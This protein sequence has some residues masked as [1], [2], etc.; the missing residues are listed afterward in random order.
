MTMDDTSANYRQFFEAQNRRIDTL[1]GRRIIVLAAVAIILFGLVVALKSPWYVWMWTTVVYGVF[2]YG[3]SLLRRALKVTRAAVKDLAKVSA[4]LGEPRRRDELTEFLKNAVAPDDSNVP[5]S[6]AALCTGQA[7]GHA[8]RSAANASFAQPTSQLFVAQ[9]V[10]TSLVLAG[11]FGTVLFFA[12]ELGNEELLTGDLATLL[13]GIRGALASTLAGILG[14]VSLG[15]LASSIDQVIEESIWETESLLNGPFLQALSE[16]PVRTDVESEHQ[17]WRALI[18]EV[19]GLRRETGAVVSQLGTDVAAHTTA[20]AAL[21]QRLAGMPALQVPEELTRLNDV[22]GDFRRGMELLETSVTSIVSTAATLNVAVPA[23]TTDRLGEIAGTLE[24]LSET[25]ARSAAAAVAAAENAERRVH[26][27]L[28]GMTAAAVLSESRLSESLRLVTAGL[29][30]VDKKVDTATGK[31]DSVAAA[32]EHAPAAATTPRLDS[33]PAATSAAG[34]GAPS[35]AEPLAKVADAVATMSEALCDMRSIADSIAESVLG[36]AVSCSAIDQR[37]QAVG[38]AVA[39]SSEDLAH[40]RKS[41]TSIERK[42]GLVHQWH[43]R[44]AAAPLMRMM[45][46]FSGKGNGAAAGA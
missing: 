23:E 26:D 43:R 25:S 35:I 42:L 5:E 39:T 10:R 14:S 31:L 38:A 15:Y 8:V 27:T 12:F 33:S 36:T 1:A 24:S 2:F 34:D 3:L 18:E 30:A 17:L 28:T 7:T 11:L 20:L 37:L 21:E 46:L 6:L 45:L 44:A 29:H 19:A 4:F 32:L 13:P 9:F 41:T 40:V 22:V 16:M